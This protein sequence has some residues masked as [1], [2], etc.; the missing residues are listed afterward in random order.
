MR[1]AWFPKTDQL[2]G[3][4]PYW[5]L[6]Q[7]ALE[8]QGVEFETS[9]AGFYMAKRWLW[10]KQRRVDVLHFHFIQSQYGS[11]GPRASLRR[12]IVFAQNL[13]FAR[14]LGYRIVWTVHDL[15]P[16]WPLEPHWVEYLARLVIAHFSQVVVVHCI[17]AKELVARHFGRQAGVFVIPHPSFIGFYPDSVNKEFARKQLGLTNQKRVLLFF[18][19]IRPNKGIDRL[20]DA[21]I[22][23]QGDDWVL[24]IAGRPWQ[25]MSYVEDIV[26]RAR[27]DPRIYL[28]V[29]DIPEDKVQVYYRAADAVVL[30]FVNILTS[31]SALLAMSFGR[32]VIAPA[33][34]CLT[35]LITPDTGVLYDPNQHNGL[36]DAIRSLTGK[37]LEILG[38]NA[39]RQVKCHTWDNMAT[40]MRKLY[41]GWIAQ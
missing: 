23:L 2:V 21:F 20:I 12:V 22:S 30:P 18:G 5:K 11:E 7:S 40:E 1:V 19:G 17:K 28:S 35:E 38:K 29:E 31:S 24:L 10:A 41:Q 15:M 8:Q 13:L 32:P 16:T 39:F 6:L 27:R 34:G 26:L 36:T 9:H 33:I 25:P 14:L 37:D 4:N 3:G